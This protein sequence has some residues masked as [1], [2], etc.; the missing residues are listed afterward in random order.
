[1]PILSLTL[2]PGRLAVCRLEG[3]DPIPPW[4]VD[5]DFYSVTRV[6][7]ELSIVCDEARLP[8]EVRHEPG[9]RAF[10]VEGPLP[11]SATGILAAIAAPLAAAGIPI[12]A[13]STFD[14]DYVLVKGADAAR[15]A[16]ALRAA[17]HRIAET[18]LPPPEPP[19]KP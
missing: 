8:P 11:F 9:W 15:A 3:N 17:G 13:L 19:S 16:E 18:T 4:A 2:L 10:R 12:F 14:T 6:E 1:M 5:G 7:G